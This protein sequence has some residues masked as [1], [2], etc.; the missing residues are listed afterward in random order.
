MKDVDVPLE[1]NSP[2][3]THQI[4]LQVSFL[5]WLDPQYQSSCHFGSRGLSKTLNNLEKRK[6]HS[7]MYL[8]DI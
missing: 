7:S 1:G 4:T 6:E 2:S 5:E 3:A 8:L